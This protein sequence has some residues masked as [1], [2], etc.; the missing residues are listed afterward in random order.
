[1]L[2]VTVSGSRM[3]IAAGLTIRQIIAECVMCG[4]HPA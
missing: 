4:D 3:V 2:L 1:M